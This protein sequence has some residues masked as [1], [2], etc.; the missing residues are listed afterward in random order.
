MVAR[1]LAMV[2][3]VED[4]KEPKEDAKLPVLQMQSNN[5]CSVDL[6]GAAVTLV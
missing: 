2:A 4:A 6:P 1:L 5:Q 3:M